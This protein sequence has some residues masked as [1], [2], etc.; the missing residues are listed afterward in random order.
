MRV[1][2]L[3]RDP[4]SEEVEAPLVEL[5]VPRRR[6]V[7]S[8]I[9]DRAVGPLSTR[10]GKWFVPGRWRRR[11]RTPGRGSVTPWGIEEATAGA[12]PP[13]AEPAPDAVFAV[14]I[15]VV[16]V[17]VVG[18]VPAV[19]IVAVM[20]SRSTGVARTARPT[21]FTGVTRVTRSAGPARITR[22]SRVTRPARSTRVTRPAR[23]TRVAG[24]AGVAGSTG[25]A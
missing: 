19:T 9:V 10:R 16:E 12:L 8:P 20:S 1:V 22:S 13:G 6:F 2:P 24:S 11:T 5:W 17:G 18:P 3:H 15:V 7:E 25:V 23:S 21:G 14:E 4:D